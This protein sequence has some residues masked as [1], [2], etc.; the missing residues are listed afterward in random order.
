M[1]DQP[2][3]ASALTL[4]EKAAIVEL[5][6]ASAFRLLWDGISPGLAEEIGG[7]WQE[8]GGATAIFLEKF[9]IPFFNRVV[10]LGI[11]E[12]ATEAMVDE[13]MAL[14]NRIGSPFS[15][16]LSPAAR[17]AELS[18]WLLARGFEHT[19]N[20]AKMIRGT[21]PPPEV[22][23]ALRLEK[24]DE[25]WAEH[26]ADIALVAF[27]MPEWMKPVFEQIIALPGAI[28]YLAFAEDEPAAIGSLIVSGEWGS[29]VNGATLPD[30]RRRGGQGAIMAE[31]IREGIALGC[32]WLTTE[33]GEDTP[34]SPNPSYR[35][36]LRSGFELAYL[37]PNYTY[38]PDEA[39]D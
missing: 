26:F 13:L 19:S 14:Y 36:M 33:T 12:P 6:E 37:R 32:R 24:A 35:N 4:E 39:A 31:R 22:E 15:V 29:L 28:S 5:N 11:H 16:A 30:Y 21:E 27:E 8:V 1:S 10:G 3:Q 17:P 38:Q 23:T 20:W 9:P 25:A 18:D 34:E 7:Y 2:T